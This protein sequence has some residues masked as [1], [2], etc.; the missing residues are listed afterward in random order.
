MSIKEHVLGEV[1][2]EYYRAGHLYYRTSTGIV[3]SIPID[4]C[5]DATFN[6]KDKGMFFMRWIRKHLEVASS[7]GIDY[8]VADKFLDKKD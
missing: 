7:E 2:F 6:T 1:T 5:G 3:F 8:S 4:D